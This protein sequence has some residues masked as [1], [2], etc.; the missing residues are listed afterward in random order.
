LSLANHD[1]TGAGSQLRE[2]TRVVRRICL[3]AETDRGAEASRVAVAEL[4]PLV[5]T[6]REAH[7]PDSLPDE[8]IREIQTHELERARDAAALSEILAPLLTA[9]FE[10]LREATARTGR[11]RT[12][13]AGLESAPRDRVPSP[14]EIA[15]LL[16][17][18]LAQ[19]D[20]RPPTPSRRVRPKISATPSP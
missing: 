7:G 6:Y 5:G 19:D 17:G 14:P 13:P 18:M 8:R 11:V 4:D 15:D 1:S 16:D 12:A 9:H 3:L 2:I 10:R 20:S